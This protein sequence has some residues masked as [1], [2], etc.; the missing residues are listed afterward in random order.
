MS[1]SPE[2]DDDFV[3]LIKDLP[4]D[5]APSRIHRESLHRDVMSR[6]D[7]LQSL[8][9]ETLKDF[10]LPRT[11]RSLR[12]NFRW[13]AVAAICLFAMIGWYIFRSERSPA[14]VFGSLTTSFVDAK[15]ARF[16]IDVNQDLLP[17]QIVRAFY[18]APDRFRQ[19]ISHNGEMT[20]RIFDELTGKRLMLLP[21][22]KTAVVLNTTGPM[23]Q[24]LADAFFQLREFLSRNRDLN[25]SPFRSVGTRQI[26]RKQAI[27]FV[28]DATFGEVT[29]WGD[30]RTSQLLQI[31]VT[32]KATRQQTILRDFEFNIDLGTSLFDLAPPM[33]YKLDV[34][35]NSEQ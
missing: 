12:A 3:R 16:Q 27:G 31:E 30:S 7:R 20:I 14:A 11:N 26:D 5:D 10:H 33:G 8:K 28:S 1:G 15:T 25:N 9:T 18:Q 19:E 32:W 6:F 29:L 21:A 24:S 23:D 13:M 35:P 17:A 4:F 34:D 2:H 22:T